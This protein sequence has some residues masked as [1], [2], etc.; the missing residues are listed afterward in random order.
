MTQDLCLKILLHL[1]KESGEDAIIFFF[2]EHIKKKKI[3]ADNY[4]VM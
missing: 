3:K 2:Y 1:L 4:D